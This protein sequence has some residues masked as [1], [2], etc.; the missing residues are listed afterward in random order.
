VKTALR[1]I[2]SFDTVTTVIPGTKNIEQLH[3]NSY[4]SSEKL[5]LKIKSKLEELYM[6]YISKEDTP[7]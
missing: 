7:W 5:S 4:A 2:L 3:L 1:F 6:D